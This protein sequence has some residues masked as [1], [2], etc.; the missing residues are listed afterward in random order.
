MLTSLI[1]HLMSMKVREM[2][3]TTE[4]RALAAAAPIESL[5]FLVE[6]DNLNDA[7]DRTAE[8]NLTDVGVGEKVSILIGSICFNVLVF[9]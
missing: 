4:Q 5:R 9:C 3:E 1:I 2:P 6:M 8:E 7:S